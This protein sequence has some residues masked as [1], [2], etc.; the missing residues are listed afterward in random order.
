MSLYSRRRFGMTLAAATIAGCGFT[1][2][3][4]LKG[5]GAALLGQ[6]SM[7]KPKNRNAYLLQQRIE[8]RLGQAPSGEW[9]LIPRITTENI[10]LGYTEDGKITRYNITGSADYTL[11]RAGS[12]EVSKQGKVEHFTSYS[13]TS[14][15]VVT[16]AAERDA[17]ARLMTILA[18]QI[19]D[20][21][22]LIAGDLRV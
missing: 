16:L 3:Y 4:G 1:P 20:Q 13:A 17:R 12:Q 15:T 19:I 5:E 18:D 8:E 10:G 7:G 2:I 21:L 22:L 9:L 11:Q 14:T 6:I